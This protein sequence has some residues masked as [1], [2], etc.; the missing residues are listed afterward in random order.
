[1]R[2]VSVWAEV[3][4]DHFRAYKSEAERRGVAIE[5]LIQQTVNSLLRELE[6]EEA[7]DRGHDLTTS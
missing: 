7:E 3:S 2:R 1:M 4:D 5:D 6:R